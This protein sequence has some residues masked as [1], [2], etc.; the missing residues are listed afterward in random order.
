MRELGGHAKLCYLL[1]DTR[2]QLLIVKDNGP[3]G[4]EI[5][6]E[7]QHLFLPWW[8]KE[9]LNVNIYVRYK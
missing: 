1:K 5:Y 6:L 8:K 3:I 9:E 2:T 4:L 7:D